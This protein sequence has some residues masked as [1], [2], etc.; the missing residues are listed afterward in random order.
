MNSKINTALVIAIGL[1]SGCTSDDAFESVPVREIRATLDSFKVEESLTRTEYNISETSGFQTVW[2]QGDILGIYPIGGDQVS[3]PISDGIGTTSAKFDG[4]SWALRGTYKYAAYYPFSKDC[5]TIDQTAIPVSFTGQVQDGNNTT[6]HLADYD[7]MAAAGTQPSENGSVDLRFKHIGCFLRM[8][9]TMPV[10]GT[11]TEVDIQ[12]DGGSFTTTGTVNLA[13]TAP[14]LSSTATTNKLTLGLN[15]VKT[16]SANQAITLYMMVA[17]DNLSGSTLTFTVKDSN[18]KCYTKTAA[19]KNMLATYA[20]NYSLTLESTGTG[21]NT[22][23]G[24][25]D[26]S[27][28]T[29]DN[30]NS[31]TYDQYVGW[32]HDENAITNDMFKTNSIAGTWTSSNTP[33]QSIDTDIWYFMICTT[34][35]LKCVKNYFVT[36]LPENIKLGT[37]T[38][39]GTIYDVYKIGPSMYTDAI[40]EIEIN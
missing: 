10:A 25:W 5:Y 4:G 2:A 32:V 12:T 27:S 6:A 39:N 37:K 29:N 16:T 1:L 9:L 15:N 7:F 24:G 26:D 30:E 35:S 11:F 36:Y 23:G 3:F 31:V 18:D 20:Y 33:S 34:Q 28:A 40:M 13:E 8:Q 17:P 19:G 22:D 14:A 38:L 21:G